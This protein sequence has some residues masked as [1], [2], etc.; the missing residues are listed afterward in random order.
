MRA[1]G[2]SA[3]IAELLPA[4]ALHCAA[5][6]ISLYPVV[7]FG[8]LFEFGPLHKIDE[9]LIIL[10]K[11]VID[12]VFSAGHPYVVYASALQTV[13]FFAGGTPVVIQLRL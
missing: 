13:V 12:P 6:L 3:R 4:F 9:F 8:A 2:S 10:V 1:A 5:P 7:A 11:A